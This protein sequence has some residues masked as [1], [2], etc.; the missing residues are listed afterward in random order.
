MSTDDPPSAN[1]FT[2]VESVI[3]KTLERYHNERSEG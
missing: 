3:P 2:D 1:P